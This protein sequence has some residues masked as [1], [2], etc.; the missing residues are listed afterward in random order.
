MIERY[1]KIRQY[2][3]GANETRFETK[4]GRE[5]FYNEVESSILNYKNKGHRAAVKGAN[6]SHTLFEI[7]LPTQ[8]KTAPAGAAHQKFDE[9]A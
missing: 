1:L 9:V 2:A 8:T 6:V 3:D 4:H 7:L 5:L